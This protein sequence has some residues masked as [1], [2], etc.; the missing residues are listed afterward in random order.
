M[1][2][3]KFG[4]PTSR[5]LIDVIKMV[6]RS[7]L[8]CCVC[9]SQ[10]Y[11]PRVRRDGRCWGDTR[12]VSGYRVKEGRSHSLLSPPEAAKLTTDGSRPVVLLL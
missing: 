10:S 12:P 1:V 11:D 5:R 6:T 3:V 8:L 4:I 7:T 2:F 9:P